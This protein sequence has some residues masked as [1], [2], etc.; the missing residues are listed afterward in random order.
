M[1]KKVD[2]NIAFVLPGQAKEEL[3]EQA[4]SCIR[5]SRVDSLVATA[6]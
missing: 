6:I 4:L 5:L 3:S 1:S 2:I